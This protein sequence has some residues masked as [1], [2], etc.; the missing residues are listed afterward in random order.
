MAMAEG[1]EDNEQQGESAAR[2][3]ASPMAEEQNA[4]DVHAHESQQPVDHLLY[5]SGGPTPPKMLRSTIKDSNGGAESVETDASATTIT[6]NAEAIDA[7]GHR[8]YTADHERDFYVRNAPLRGSSSTFLAS[9]TS[10]SNFSSPITSPYPSSDSLRSFPPTKDPSSINIITMRPAGG[11]PLESRPQDTLEPTKIRHDPAVPA[12][13]PSSS[14]TST[15]ATTTVRRDD[16]P[17][18]L[19]PPPSTTPQDVPTRHQLQK[20]SAR[21]INVQQNSHT[22]L[23]PSRSYRRHPFMAGFSSADHTPTESADPFSSPSRREKSEEESE[24][25]YNRTPL[26]QPVEFP[27]PKELVLRFIRQIL[28]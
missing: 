16:L 1:A 12:S 2:E 13:S 25:A 17:D 28:I 15:Q 9:L 27:E 26:L 7:D 4:A 11:R 5:N 21:N 6:S 14:S 24:E 23:S 20:S 8:G 3:N 22:S 19:D 18:H 10:A